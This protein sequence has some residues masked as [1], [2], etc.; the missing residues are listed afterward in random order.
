MAR[1]ETSPQ[2]PKVVMVVDNGIAGD[3]RVQK[4]A[5]AVASHGYDVTLYG[6]ETDVPAPKLPGVT[7]KRVPNPPANRLK[8]W[9]VLL[10]NLVFFVAYKTRQSALDRYDELAIIRNR[11]RDRYPK[12]S[13]RGISSRIWYLVISKWHLVRNK[14]RQIRVRVE[15]ALKR[16]A[17]TP[18]TER[19][20]INY[21][22]EKAFLELL[23]KEK[24]DIL[25]THDYKVVSVGGLAKSALEQAGHRTVWIY[26]AHEFVPGLEQY[27]QDWREAQSAN[28][29]TYIKQADRIITVSNRLAEMLVER[30]HLDSL[31]DVVLNAP[32]VGEAIPATRNLR[33]DCG[34][35]EDTPLA[36]YLGGI[37]PMR[38]LDTVINALEFIPELHVS[39]VAKRNV[40]VDA[41]EDRAYQLGAKDRLHIVPYVSPNEI[42]D[43]IKTAT[44]G[45]VPLLFTI[46]HS[47]A[48]PSKFYEYACAGVPI[49]G[50]DVGEIPIM[51]NRTGVGEVFSAGSVESFVEQ[52]NKMLANRS[53]YA[54]RFEGSVL[55]T[56][57]WENQALVLGEIY[58]EISDAINHQ[59]QLAQ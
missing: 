50:S 55:E 27:A 57:T 46:N 20:T 16:R 58:Q 33:A 42:V 52:M 39:L 1:N 38:G 17:G 2:K 40:H 53:E 54:S 29:A 45:V 36:I 13:V 31:P 4:C 44:I 14:A 3:S 9:Q 43:Y 23:L 59:S 7:I 11:N 6:T 35:G 56:C 47:S 26:D 21:R 41:L 15:E 22:Y 49:L 51:L 12:F 32:T 10:L 5:V 34:I 18:D 24:P 19:P 48:L 28:E 30:H 8:S 37:S 25:H